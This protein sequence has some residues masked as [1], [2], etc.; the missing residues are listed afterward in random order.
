MKTTFLPFVFIL[1]LSGCGINSS[2]TLKPES[3]ELTDSIE[4]DLTVIIPNIE[5]HPLLD[6][7]INVLN[8]CPIPKGNKIEMFISVEQRDYGLELFFNT[9]CRYYSDSSSKTS[10]F[11]YKGFRFYYTGVFLDNYFI[12]TDNIIKMRFVNPSKLIFDIDDRDYKWV[13]AVKNGIIEGILV[14]DCNKLWVN[15]DYFP[16]ED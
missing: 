4:L 10:I 16:G 7:I 13:Y 5:L 1:I 12:E 6:S 11:D 8:S 14:K 3:S 2:K 9:I 15:W